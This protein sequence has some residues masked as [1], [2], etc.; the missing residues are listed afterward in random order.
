MAVEKKGVIMKI[1]LY[2]NLFS[3]G[4]LIAV[5]MSGCADDKFTQNDNNIPKG[6]GIVFGANA[7]YSG[8]SQSRTEYGEYV[9]DGTGKKI[10]QKIKWLKTDK[11]DIYSPASPTLTKVE[12]G[13]TKVNENQAY[14]LALGDGLQWDRTASTQDFYAIYPSKESMSNEAVKK[15]VSFDNGVLKGYVPV[16]QQ[17][18]ITKGG[19]TGWTATPNMDY[20]YMAAVQKGYSIPA[21]DAQD[22]GVSLH[23]VPLTT[24]LE[25]TIEGPTEAP[26]ASINVFANNGENI[27]GYFSCDLKKVGTTSDINNDLNCDYEQSATVRNM[28]T[29]S[30]YYDDGGTQKPLELASGE[31]ITFNVFLLPHTDLDNISVR[32]AGFNTASKT[33]ALT[34]VTL[35]PS[36]K[37]CV[38][39]K[40]PQIA[41]DGEN[42][43]ITGM[44]EKVLISQLSIPGTANSFS[45]NYSGTNAEYYKAQTAPFEQQWN[46]GIRCFELR[47]PNNESGNSLDGV[48]LQCNRE[49]L[50]IT[51]GQAVDMIWEKVKNTGEFAMIMP[52]FESNAGRDWRVTDFADDLN[53]FFADHSGYKYVTYGRELTV[54]D[55]RGS[56][57]F[58]ARITSEEDGGLE[59]PAP[60]QG[61]F[62]DQWG[63]LK[64]NWA[65]RGYP[66]DNWGTND[67][68]GKSMENFMITDNTT[69]RYGNPNSN[70]DP[71]KMPIKGAVDYIHNTTR[72][73][74]STGTAY[75][76]DWA[77]VVKETKNF[78]LYEAYDRKYNGNL[79]PPYYDYY[80]D[81]TQ[82]VY[83]KESLSEKQTDIWSTFELAIDDNN[84]QQGSTFYINCLDGYYVDEK[85]ELSF[86]PFIGGRTDSYRNQD[87]D[88]INYS[89]GNGGVAGNIDAFANDI[90]DW[91]YNEILKYGASN[92]Y[93]PM[94]IVILDRVYEAGG[95]SYLPSVIINNNYRFPLIT[96]DDVQGQSNSDASY[97]SGG[98]VIE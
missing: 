67:N 97:T 98:N 62:I 28:I 36:Q 41:K 39:L 37:T 4:A 53:Q 29:I 35:H 92:I 85:V 90:N 16:N 5:A 55:A 83:W 72:K 78:K 88:N 93:G 15:V 91:F 69:D 96:I 82:F 31:S 64:D 46:A 38:K 61:V 84:N 10:S 66:V 22:N 95:G 17:H 86:K 12:Y 1:K 89:Y 68:F 75:I 3:L 87:W 34:G 57:M 63:S 8:G 71:S 7:S 80:I 25:L 74:G 2:L 21:T 70:F 51:F 20:L 19:T 26:I 24:T 30:G 81:H 60:G 76:Q 73:G 9:T 23:F 49:N 44:D 50:G 32:I 79:I 59:L 77:R 58:I 18:T 65:R 94:N 47:C 54:G 48:Q 43:W 27:A 42:N 13:I 40:A 56:L 6:N 11:V 52:A 45:S 33:M 14:L